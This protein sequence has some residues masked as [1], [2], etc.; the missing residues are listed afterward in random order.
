MNKARLRMFRMAVLAAAVGMF[1][2]NLWAQ[3]PV[4]RAVAAAVAAEAGKDV[5]TI[6]KLTGL[7]PE[8]RAKTPEYAV[9]PSE[10]SQ[11][12]DWVKITVTYDTESEWTDEL[13]FRYTAVVKHPKTGAF[14]LFPCSVTYV[15]IAKGRNHMSTVFLSP[16]TVERYGGLDRVAVEIYAKGELAASAGLPDTPAQWWRLPLS[17]VR[18]MQGVLLNRAQ[19]PFAFVAWDNYETIKGR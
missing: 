10:N 2:G 6:R 11:T 1:C 9:S 18:T 8:G 15:D 5:V 7:G 12:R 16:K 3:R 17:N 14:T 19:T 13:E 4:G